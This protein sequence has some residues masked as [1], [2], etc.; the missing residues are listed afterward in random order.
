M[1]TII[2]WSLLLIVAIFLGGLLMNEKNNTA[3]V[4][5]LQISSNSPA[6]GQIVLPEQRIEFA[7]GFERLFHGKGMEA[8]VTTNG[9]QQKVVTIS[10]KIVNETS[11][12]RM[13]DNVDAIQDL[14]QEGFM[15]LIMIDGK[16]SWDI[17]LKN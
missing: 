9:D 7:K 13:K 17:D 11:V 10:G 3:H 15:H 6:I 2:V 5:Y 16:V 14:R 12:Y 8:T 1:K 4:N